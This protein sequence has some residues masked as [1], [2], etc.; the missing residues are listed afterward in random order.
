MGRDACAFSGATHVLQGVSSR[1]TN[2]GTACMLSRCSKAATQISKQAHHYVSDCSSHVQQYSN[3][4]IHSL[5]NCATA[6]MSLCCHC[7]QSPGLWNPVLFSFYPTAAAASVAINVATLRSGFAQ[8]GAAS[9][10]DGLASLAGFSV[11]K[12]PAG[13]TY[14]VFILLYAATGA[15][16]QTGCTAATASCQ[17]PPTHSY[18]LSPHSNCSAKINCCRQCNAPALTAVTLPPLL[19][20]LPLQL[21]PATLPK[22]SSQASP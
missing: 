15:Y 16:M 9:V 8:S 2:A 11:P 6:A 7:V 14:S 19:L 22:S 12:T 20:L 5:S 18:Q 13:W 4:S 3:S 1:C 17:L 21:L 10:K